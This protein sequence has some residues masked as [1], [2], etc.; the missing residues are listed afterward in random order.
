MSQKLQNALNLIPDAATR[1]AIT[2]VLGWIKAEY[3][4]HSHD[5]SVGGESLASSTP[6]CDGRASMFPEK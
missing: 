6:K 2:E 1:A 4:G 5:V 3:D